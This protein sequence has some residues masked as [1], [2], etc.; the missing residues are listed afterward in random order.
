MTRLGLPASIPD[1][2]SAQALLGRMRLDKK[3]ISGVLRL[4]LWRGIGAAEVVGDVPDSEIL[5]VL[6]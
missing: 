6:A 3:A 5:Q 2:L 1:G 4:I